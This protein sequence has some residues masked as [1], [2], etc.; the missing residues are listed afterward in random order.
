MQLSMKRNG[1]N[2]KTFSSFYSFQI[3]SSQTLKKSQKVT[4]NHKKLSHPKSI[5]ATSEQCQNVVIH[6]ISVLFQLIVR[7]H[8]WLEVISKTQLLLSNVWTELWPDSN[9]GVLKVSNVFKFVTR[10]YPRWAK[11]SYSYDGHT[12]N[13]FLDP[14]SFEDGC[15][16]DL[17]NKDPLAPD[18]KMIYLMESYTNVQLA[19]LESRRFK[20]KMPKCMT[21]PRFQTNGPRIQDSARLADWDVY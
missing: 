13:R 15:A 20:Q 6:T 14:R 5:W 11:M 17:K 2:F 21:T 8:W 1:G 9:P 12:V 4:Q 16:K 7:T 3:W 18:F 19:W 10:S